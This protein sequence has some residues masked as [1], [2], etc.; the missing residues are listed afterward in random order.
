M[1]KKKQFVVRSPS[2]LGENVPLKVDRNSYIS[3]DRRFP[4]GFL[5]VSHGSYLT[6][7]AKGSPPRNSFNHVKTADVLMPP[8]WNFGGE[9]IP[10][11][12]L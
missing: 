12:G 5:R 4:V 9:E 1:L 3:M 7:F 2:I 6:T 10:D 11:G 8:Y